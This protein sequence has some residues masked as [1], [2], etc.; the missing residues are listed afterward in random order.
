MDFELVVADS[1]DGDG[2]GV[3]IFI[4]HLGW[5]IVW[6]EHPSSE[7]LVQFANY[8]EASRLKVPVA[9]AV[10]MIEAARERLDRLEHA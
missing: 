1:P 6:R 8:R 3:E 4:G 10:M 5:A 2:S 9:D 7:P